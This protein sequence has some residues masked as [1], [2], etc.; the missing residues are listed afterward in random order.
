ML[1]IG[2]STKTIMKWITSDPMELHKM[3]VQ[4][5]LR[6]PP[7]S[8]KILMSKLNTNH[9]AYLRDT[10][11]LRLY[12]DF[13]GFPKGTMAKVIYE[14]EPVKFYNWWRKNE[15]KVTMSRLELIRLLLKV[16]EMSPK[17]L[18][19][20]HKDLLKSKNWYSLIA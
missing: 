2:N 7:D 16:Q 11:G 5:D 13:P 18:V 8:Y 15:D 3:I 10:L 19:K 20:R 17:S 9:F 4:Y 6:I 1:T 14:Q 12:I